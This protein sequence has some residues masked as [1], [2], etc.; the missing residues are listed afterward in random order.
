MLPS[1][2][3]A[4]ALGR[5]VNGQTAFVVGVAEPDIGRVATVNCRYGLPDAPTANAVPVVEI[6]VS[7][8]DTVDDA[9]KRIPATVDDYVA[10]GATKTGTTVA[11]T[12]ATILTGGTGTGYTAATIVLAAGQRTVVAGIVETPAGADPT[13]DL[14]ALATLAV[15]NSGA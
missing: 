2:A 5:P 11:G 12:P 10:H 13:K 15:T 7:L 3:V 4:N 6:G 9:A 1:P 8:Y 14:V